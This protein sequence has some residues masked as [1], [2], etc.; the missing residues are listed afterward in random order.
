MNKPVI[1]DPKKEE[2]FSK[3]EYSWT[4]IT[5]IFE[6]FFVVVVVVVC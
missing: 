2:V 3:I 4:T 1:I 6:G 5:F